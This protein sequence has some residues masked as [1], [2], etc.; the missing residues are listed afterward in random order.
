M[1]DIKLVRE[2]PELVRKNLEKRNNPENLV[3]LKELIETDKKWRSIT[4]EVNLLRKKRNELSSEIAKLKKEKKP[5][6]QI[7]RE[8]E[9]IP[10][11]IKDLEVHQKQLEEKE[12]DLLFKI[13]NMLHDSVPTGKDSAQNKVLKLFGKKPKF[14]F[15]PKSHLEILQNLKMIDQ[16]RATKVAGN[17]FV[18]LKGDLVFLDMAIQRFALDFL[19]KKGFEIVYPPLMINK[20]AYQGMIGNPFDFMEASYKLEGEDLFLNPTAEYPIGSMFENEIFNKS[21]LP[22]KV[23]GVATSFRREV[24]THGKYAKGLFRMHHFNKVEQ[25]IFCLPEDSWKLFEELQRNS[26]TLYEILGLHFRTVVLCSGD[27]GA[28]ASETIDIEAWMADGEFREVGSNSNCLDYQARRLG[29]RYREGEGKPVS[30]FIHT[31][32]NTA[33]AT[34][35]TMIAIIEQYQQKDGSVEIPKALRS[36]TGFDFL[37]TKK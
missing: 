6:A 17:S 37:G 12:R 36:Y 13:P 29:I 22:K 28:K 30:G 33:L 2:N 15:V 24:G 32:N 20:T 34:S 23:C 8:A 16:E 31:L 25:F 14:D 10:E 4:S 1:L 26:E 7:L 9:K 21:D 11:K 5:V 3:F 19:K 27:T 35:R 18:Y